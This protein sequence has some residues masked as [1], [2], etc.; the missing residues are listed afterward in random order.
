ME[1]EVRLNLAGAIIALVL[2]GLIAVALTRKMVKPL[3]AASEAAKCIA[4]GK[5]DVPIP[6]G[7]S[8]ELGQLLTSM[9]AM[10]DNIKKMMQ[11]EIS[12]RQSAQVRLV[13]AL[14]GSREGIILVEADKTIALANAQAAS[15]LSLPAET[16]K[17]GTKVDVIESTVP[18]AAPEHAILS[19]NRDDTNHDVQL[20]DGRW[21]RVSRN[22][23][24]DGGFMVVCSDITAS[25][26]QEAKL[27]ESN[28]LLDA[29]LDNMSQGLCLFSADEHLQIANRRFFEIFGLD[30]T[31]IFA[32]MTLQTIV[33]A[34]A[35]LKAVGKILAEIP[36]VG[37][38]SAQ[39][40]AL[41]TGYHKLEDGR[42]IASVY[43]PTQEGG[44]VATFEDVTE[45]RQAEARIMHM[46]RHDA[47][48]D[49]PNRLHF[50]ER[51]ENL[52]RKGE[53]LSILFI[54][55]DRFK[56]VNDTLGHPLGDVLLCAVAHRLRTALRESD[57]LARL[58][59]GVR[60]PTDCRRAIGSEQ[61]RAKDCRACLE[62]LRSQRPSCHRR[63]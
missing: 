18:N 29:A 44:W 5:L 37:G 60:G 16:L 39:S 61:S 33:Q 11:G 3:A 1:H 36:R 45:R 4:A 2:S 13:E 14:E 15:F 20:L 21:L 25:K 55:L 30:D 49:L 48:T 40:R 34:G 31:Q 54:D 22:A 63:S 43:N 38:S 41:G 50:R 62:T 26:E 8:D 19:A 51:L 58:G 17:T 56:N 32:G 53:D 28:I 7:G 57:F 59:G 24:S 46:A 27:Q 42:T 9:G 10:R 23:T 6:P 52:L 47:L 12:L 35:Q